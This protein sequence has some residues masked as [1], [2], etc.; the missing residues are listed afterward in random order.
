MLDAYFPNHPW[1]VAVINRYFDA[2]RAHDRRQRAIARDQH[3]STCGN[4]E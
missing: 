2:E 1:S 4:A 3:Q